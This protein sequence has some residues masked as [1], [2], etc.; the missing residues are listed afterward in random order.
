M[1]ET[2]AGGPQ[3]THTKA[4]GPKGLRAGC[5]VALGAAA[6]AAAAE[7]V[8]AHP[9][10]FFDATAEIFMG[11]DRTIESVRVRYVIDEFNTLFVVAELELDQDGDSV[12][13]DD[14]QARVVEGMSIGL[15]PFGYYVDLR[16]GEERLTFGA[17]MIAVTL[18]DDGRM[19][20]EIELRLAEP[21][22]IA[23]GDARLTLYDPT[24]FTAVSLIEPPV[25]L[26]EVAGCAV[27]FRAFEPSAL[28]AR[29]QATLAQL[30][31]EE[32][33][34]TPDVG[35]LFADQTEVSCQTSAG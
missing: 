21:A 11:P 22:P 1:I 10:M 13:N 23:E 14:D 8:A 12:L 16:V 30:S 26:G 32:T 2:G 28:L 33:P 35:A 29:E 9:H 24:Y 31:R 15:A 5:V 19:V 34:E 27:L 4:A 7:P 17:P 25:L 6:I 3:A 20:T 18:R